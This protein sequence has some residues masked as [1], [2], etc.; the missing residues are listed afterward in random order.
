MV[1]L[2]MIGSAIYVYW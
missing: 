2:K 1:T